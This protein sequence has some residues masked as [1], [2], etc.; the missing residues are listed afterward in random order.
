MVRSQTCFQKCKDSHVQ[1]ME[2]ALGPSSRRA[3]QLMPPLNAL[4]GG[5]TNRQDVDDL[6]TRLQAVCRANNNFIRCIR[7]CS[8]QN[9]VDILVKGQTAWLIICSAFQ[10]YTETF[11]SSILTCWARYGDEM[12][13]G[14]A[15]EELQ[16]ESA[17]HQI[18]TNRQDSIQ[19]HY[20]LLC[21]NVVQHDV[22]YI[23][24]V[25]RL[26]DRTA[27]KFLLQMNEKSFIAMTELFRW[28]DR[29]RSL[30]EECEHW[31]SSSQYSALFAERSTAPRKA[32]TGSAQSFFASPLLVL[33]LICLLP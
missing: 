22:C 25:K 10:L 33:L 26:C 11:I 19:S 24:Q 12:N 28:S 17:F 9:T 1:E 18:A 31:I 21:R 30:P 27:F 16:L 23:R 2:N 32:R 7:K 6:V 20:P 8:D 13:E 5:A 4:L 15:A 14:C 3:T 29:R